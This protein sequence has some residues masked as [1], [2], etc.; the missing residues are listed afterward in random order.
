MAQIAENRTKSQN[1]T[2]LCVLTLST[3][4][5]HI[6][7]QII[8]IFGISLVLVKVNKSVKYQDEQTVAHYI[9]ALQSW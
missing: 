2:F 7:G 4:H 8:V 1:Y 6:L 9:T 3:R 5:V